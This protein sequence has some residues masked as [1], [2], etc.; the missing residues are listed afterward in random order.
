M[1]TDLFLILALAVAQIS[2][3]GSPSPS[4]AAAPASAARP[5]SSLTPPPREVSL[6]T[7]APAARVAINRRSKNFFR[8]PDG[9]ILDLT[10]FYTYW[11]VYNRSIAARESFS[12]NHLGNKTITG[13]WVEVRDT[14]ETRAWK[15]GELNNTAN[16]PALLQAWKAGAEVATGLT[17]FK[18]LYCLATVQVNRQN[19]FI[20]FVI[21]RDHPWD[22]YDRQASWEVVETSD[23]EIRR[24]RLLS[25]R[26]RCDRVQEIQVRGW[27]QETGVREYCEMIGMGESGREIRPGD[28]VQE[29][30]LR[31][32]DQ[33]TMPRDRTREIIQSLPPQEVYARVDP[34]YLQKGKLKPGDYILYPLFSP[35][36]NV[37]SSR[38]P[39]VIDGMRPVFSA[40][41]NMG[42]SRKVQVIDGK[43]QRI[44]GIVRLS[45]WQMK[46]EEIAAAVANGELSLVEWSYT[47][48]GRG[49]STKVTWSSRTIPHVRT[50]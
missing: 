41:L 14:A 22:A 50:R 30:G 18:E 6:S 13:R 9:T 46:P 45:E 26:G 29:I 37:E 48:E 38:Q 44:Y 11:S 49:E 43:Q 31:D 10:N 28:R 42:P 24:V 21:I 34:G 12:V 33:Q 17:S 15:V 19:S 39:P 36:S 40:P 4:P 23:S 5:A 47:T 2:A 27:S 7:L 32:P 20:P 3:A 25:T 16:K 8:M 1:L 35:T